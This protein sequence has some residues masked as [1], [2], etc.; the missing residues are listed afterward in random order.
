MISMPVR[1]EIVVDLFG[2]DFKRYVRD[3][4]GI[5]VT[6]KAGINRKTLRQ[7]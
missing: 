2:G 1:R 3:S 6:W 5:A 7:A 4:S